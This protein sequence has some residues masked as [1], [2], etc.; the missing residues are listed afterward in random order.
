MKFDEYKPKGFD[1]WEQYRRWQHIADVCGVMIAI[2]VTVGT[3][4]TCRVY[5]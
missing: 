5:Q 4:A 2:L 3:L 1:S